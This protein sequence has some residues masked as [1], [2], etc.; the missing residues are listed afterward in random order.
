ML[1]VASMLKVFTNIYSYLVFRRPVYSIVACLFVAAVCSTY[2]GDFRLDASADSLLMEGDQELIYSR[3]I[4]SRYGI[5]E[6]VIVAFTPNE[7]LF[8]RESLDT[9]S[10][11]SER[12][13][14]I[15]TIESVDSIL[16][17]PIFSDTPLTGI[18]EN[19]LTLLD[20]ETDLE[21]ARIELVSSPV[22]RNAVVSPD[23]RTAGI[24]VTF[25]ADEVGVAL[26]E[27]RTLL[28]TLRDAGEANSADLQE[29]EQVEDDY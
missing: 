19:Y 10:E 24:L 2:I 29:L 22:F 5:Q 28:R 3:E 27:Q 9:L 15:K 8:S 20:E 21:A 26:L 12:L 16:N 4:N 11:I 7:D 25:I 18:S 6:S 23:G 13:L 1:T 14:S 17:V